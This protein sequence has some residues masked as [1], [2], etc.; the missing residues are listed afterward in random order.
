M[1]MIKITS[2]PMEYKIE[3]E[4]PRFQLKQSDNPEQRMHRKSAELNIDTSDIKVRLD[5]TEM[6][7]SIGLK[8]AATILAEGAQRGLNS[9][10]EAT[11]KYAQFGNQ[12]AQIN[13]GV[14]VSSIISQQ[15]LRQPV[16]QTVFLPT[17]G[18][19]ISWNPAG[20]DITYNSGSLEFDWEIEKNIMEY[21]P[22]K[23]TMNIIQYPKVT[24]EYLGGPNYVPPSADPS[25][26]EE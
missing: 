25:Y 9:A 19:E 11:A 21:I 16:T 17:V 18:P 7:S 6:R 5:T 23:Y 4:R 20:I 26:V 24:I 3:I 15:M 14:T 13:K 2:T 8:S 1:Q 12:M 10:L 22:G